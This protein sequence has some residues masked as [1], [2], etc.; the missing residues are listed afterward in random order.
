MPVVSVAFALWRAATGTMHS[1]ELP[2]SHSRRM[3]N[4]KAAFPHFAALQEAVRLMVNDSAFCRSRRTS[5]ADEMRDEH[6]RRV[7]GK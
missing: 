1:A 5:I 3:A 6:R 2:A 7:L 4:D